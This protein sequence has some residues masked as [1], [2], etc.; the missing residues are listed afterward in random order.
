[1]AYVPQSAWIVN[2]T[3]K[4][5]VIL[6]SDGPFDAE[7]YDRALDVCE[8][9]SDLDILPGRDHTE[10]GEKGINLSGGQ[11]QRVSLAR[12]A[13]SGRDIYLFDDPLSALDA[14]VAS[15]IFENFITR[16]LR[17][18][19]RI[20][21]THALHFLPM[22]DRIIVM[23]DGE[24]LEQGTFEEL[25][26]TAPA[27]RELVATHGIGGDVS[28]I[29]DDDKDDAERQSATTESDAD[30]TKKQHEGKLV[31]KD[32]R[33]KGIVRL[34][35]VLEY[36]RLFGLKPPKSLD[37]DSNSSTRKGFPLVVTL[38][39][40]CVAYLSNETANILSSWWLSHW[41]EQVEAYNAT[42]AANASAL[43]VE[44]KPSNV[45]YLGVY[46]AF[47]IARSLAILWRP[48]GV[49]IWR[50]SSVYQSLLRPHHLRT[51]SA[52]FILRRNAFGSHHCALRQRCRFGR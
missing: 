8:L 2:A 15:A 11:K 42:I 14:H 13:Y 19:T 43:S 35:Y 50:P 28:K 5:N 41:S 21:V 38:T 40:L 47:A 45:F 16:S 52:R 24:I 22:C 31:Q 6:A 1:M 36:F 27:F 48:S 32:A 26:G 39:F 9:K 23:G 12:A 49:C 29:D 46:S 18:K 17:N 4:K 7:R 51:K 20:I 44:D 3:L 37:V 34:Q 30:I 10:I 25:K 33:Q